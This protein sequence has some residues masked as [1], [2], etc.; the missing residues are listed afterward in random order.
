MVVLSSSNTRSRSYG[1]ENGFCTLLL[2]HIR[3]QKNVSK[4]PQNYYFGDVKIFFSGEGAQ[5]PP[6][7][8]PRTPPPRRLA[9]PLS[10]ILNTPLTMFQQSLI[11]GNSLTYGGKLNCTWACNACVCSGACSILLLTFYHILFRL[12]YCQSGAA[13]STDE[14][15]LNLNVSS[16]ACIINY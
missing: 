15:E 14:F 9:A 12:L 5:P 2:H 16:A 6:Q 3:D 11:W 7:T 1:T 10:E 8:P 4:C 13:E